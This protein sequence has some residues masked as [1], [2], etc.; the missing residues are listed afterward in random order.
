MKSL[1]VSM[2]SILESVAYAL[3]TLDM[4][5]TRLLRKTDL[6]TVTAFWPQQT[7]ENIEFL[8]AGDFASDHV[9][10]PFT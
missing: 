7:A 1:N 8:R 3:G 10:A 4:F 9:R 5:I 2:T 6:K